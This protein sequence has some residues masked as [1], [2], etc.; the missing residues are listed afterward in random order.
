MTIADLTA[1][2]TIELT[3]LLY[4]SCQR[5]T[6]TQSISGESWANSGSAF[7]CSYEE[8]S[9]A[10]QGAFAHEAGGGYGYDVWML[11]DQSIAAGDRIVVDSMT[12]SV[13][14]ASEEGAPGPLRRVRTRRVS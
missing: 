13:L 5:Q 2:A 6:V 4:R 11:P 1:A 7:V 9:P 3:Q 14:E 12:F 8:S 10:A